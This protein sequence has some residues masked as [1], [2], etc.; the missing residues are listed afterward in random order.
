M[1]QRK[2]L[3]IERGRKNRQ[4]EKHD[5][6]GEHVKSFPLIKGF[7]RQEID[8]RKKMFIY[9]TSEVE[10]RSYYCSITIARCVVFIFV[11]QYSR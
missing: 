4:K 5:V 10:S 6:L 8:F 3:T 2:Y 11:F 9:D 7:F 1:I